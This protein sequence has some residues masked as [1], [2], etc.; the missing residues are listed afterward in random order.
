M[1]R[2]SILFI[3]CI[4]FCILLLSSCGGSKDSW[5]V[6]KWTGSTQREEYTVKINKDHTA[7]VTF[8]GVTTSE[9]YNASFT[10]E[11]EEV[12]DDVIRLFDEDG[13]PVNS[14]FVKFDET[15]SMYLSK[16]G[17]FSGNY[18]RLYTNPYGHLKK[19]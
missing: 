1:K 12:N 7:D 11:W 13:H 8:H 3:S 10:A 2:I 18:D 9:A 15:W 6:G 14:R 19:K 4:T 17:N 5:C 16:E